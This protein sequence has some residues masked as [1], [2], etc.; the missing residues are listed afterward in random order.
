MK[1]KIEKFFQFYVLFIS[2]ILVVAVLASS[3]IY[4]Q[5]NIS[6]YNFLIAPYNSGVGSN[7]SREL[8]YSARI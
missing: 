8:I 1:S 6:P 3:Y 7:P 2:P 4:I 5:Y